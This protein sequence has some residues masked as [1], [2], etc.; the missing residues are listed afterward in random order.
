MTADG[1]VLPDPP[2][3]YAELWY[4]FESVRRTSTWR[5]LDPLRTTVLSNLAELT[6]FA[7]P[8]DYLRLHDLIRRYGHTRVAALQ[9]G[10]DGL[11]GREADVPALTGL[12]WRI[13]DE[14]HTWSQLTRGHAD[15]TIAADVA[16]RCYGH[17]FWLL[18]TGITRAG[19]IPPPANPDQFARLI[20]HGTVRTW[21]ATLAP[22][23]AHP[24]SPYGER[25]AGL[26]DDAGLPVVAQSLREC[27]EVYQ[28]RRQD[29]ERI[30][31][32][33]EV[34]RLIER[35]G[36]NQRTFASYIGTSSSRLST[37][38]SGKVTPSA[39]LIL[40]MR[41]SARMLEKRAPG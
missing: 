16:G 39:A 20:R 37:Y 13:G 41:R 23:A 29:E 40:R 9:D 38:A 4:D 17:M 6:T 22:V 28:L 2:D 5:G 18:L 3:R 32:S 27:Q 10:L 12:V 26:A 34:C 35:S 21:R 36:V 14:R 8:D 11:I 25:L 24:W 31:V 33:R 19:R 15:P 7:R 1:S 30:A